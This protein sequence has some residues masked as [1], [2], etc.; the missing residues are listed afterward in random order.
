[1]GAACFSRGSG[2]SR[3]GPRSGPGAPL[4]AASRMNSLPRA[5][6]QKLPNRL[7]RVITTTSA[8]RGKITVF[9]KMNL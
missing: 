9:M 6:H 3:E 4:R 7:P 5:A 1:M 2:F 8:A